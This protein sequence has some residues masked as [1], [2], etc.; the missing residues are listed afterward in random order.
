MKN[1]N[2]FQNGFF[3]VF[4]YASLHAVIWLVCVRRSVFQRIFISWS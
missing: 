4:F 1:E 3:F 2:V